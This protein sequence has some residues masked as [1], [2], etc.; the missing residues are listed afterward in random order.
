M[1]SGAPARRELAQTTHSDAGRV[2]RG[3]G[4]KAAVL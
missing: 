3:H 1:R 4:K 2:P